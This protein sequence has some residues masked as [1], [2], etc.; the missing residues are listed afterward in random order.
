[1]ELGKAFHFYLKYPE[2][3]DYF[4]F[5]DANLRWLKKQDR[6]AFEQECDKLSEQAQEDYRS[7]SK[8]MAA[9]FGDRLRKVNIKSNKAKIARASWQWSVAFWPVGKKQRSICWAGVW[10]DTHA[11]KA[12]A[13]PWVWIKGGRGVEERLGGILKVGENSTRDSRFS[14]GSVM[15][16]EITLDPVKGD[17]VDGDR[18]IDKIMDPLLKITG[19]QWREIW[20]LAGAKNGLA[21][22]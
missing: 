18:I 8:V 20:D 11:G 3:V 14:A 5:D 7:L 16:A 4:C 6:K 17:T 19:K 12:K 10:F 2:E 22:R 21:K 13:Y 15:L 9:R 1:M